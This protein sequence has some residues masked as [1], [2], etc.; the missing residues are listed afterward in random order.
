M[1]VT[2]IV[3]WSNTVRNYARPVDEQSVLDRIEELV[4]EEHSLWRA[5]SEGTLDAAGHERLAAVRRHLD[6]AY[7]TLRR[8]RAGQPDEGPADRD[9]PDPPNELAGPTPEPRHTEHGV[10]EQD[11]SSPDPSPGVP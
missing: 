2:R 1:S 7:E 4:A 10:H 6:H 11:S 9:V 8:R 5:E 3:T